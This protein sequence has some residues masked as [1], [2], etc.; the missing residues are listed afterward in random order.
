[1][2]TT[3]IGLVISWT[4]ALGII[5]IG[6]AYLARNEKNAAG[7]GLR[8]SPAPEAR[9]WWQVK[10]VRDVVTGLLVI[11]FTFAARDQ[12]ALLVLVIAGIPLGDMGVVLSNGGDR[13]AAFA[14]HG[15]T[16]LALV[17]AAVLLFV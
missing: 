5:A 13:R 4:G 2:V 16:A 11:V 9:G 7:F 3:W 17:V 12:L 8:V 1:M 15:V 10:G 6:A 14:I